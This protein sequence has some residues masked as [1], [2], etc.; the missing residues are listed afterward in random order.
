MKEPFLRINLIRHVG[1]PRTGKVGGGGA[2]AADVVGDLGRAGGE[3]GE[4]ER[5]VPRRRGT[6]R[7]RSS[8]RKRNLPFACDR[9]CQ[10]PLHPPLQEDHPNFFSENSPG[11]AVAALDRKKVASEFLLQEPASHW[12]VRIGSAPV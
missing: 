12:T 9:S 11:D 1:A 8:A 2:A 5:F 4:V 6:S 10:L 3:V 7:L